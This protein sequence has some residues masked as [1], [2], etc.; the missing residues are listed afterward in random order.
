MQARLKCDSTQQLQNGFQI[1]KDIVVENIKR[2]F[3]KGD[4]YDKK[5]VKNLYIDY[6]Y[7]AM[8]YNG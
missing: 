8:S 3:K 5:R 1:A 6:N 7:V 2:K 4:F